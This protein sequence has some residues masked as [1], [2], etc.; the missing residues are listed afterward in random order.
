VFANML[1]S[2]KQESSDKILKSLHTYLFT[3]FFEIISS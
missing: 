1:W 3:L 2:C